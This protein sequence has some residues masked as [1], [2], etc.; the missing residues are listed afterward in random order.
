MSHP[1]SIVILYHQ[2]EE[3]FKAGPGQSKATLHKAL[4][5]KTDAFNKHVTLDI[6][7]LD[8]HRSE[9]NGAVQDYIAAHP[10]TAAVANYL[11]VNTVINTI[12]AGLHK[13][14][15][16]S[17]NPALITLNMTLNQLMTSYSSRGDNID[18]NELNND[19]LRI[20]RTSQWTPH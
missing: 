20:I 14:L 6:R 10:G 19:L 3:M 1:L 18:W 13:R 12:N 2:I 16:D 11:A 7:L 17:N 15:W 4:Q 5:L 9:V 8:K